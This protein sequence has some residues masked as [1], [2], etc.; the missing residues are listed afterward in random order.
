MWC[1]DLHPEDVGG[2]LPQNA[3]NHLQAQGITS[4]I[5]MMNSSYCFRKLSF[6]TISITLK[7]T[8]KYVYTMVMQLSI[9]NF[10]ALNI[11]TSL[12]YTNMQIIN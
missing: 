7:L 2:I 12:K 1:E 10:K 3:G 9:Y 6:K 4:R 8:F 5:N 11:P